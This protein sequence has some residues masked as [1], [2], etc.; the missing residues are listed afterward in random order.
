MQS[1][2]STPAQI[3]AAKERLDV[4]AS[5]TEAGVRDAL[6]GVLDRETGYIRPVHAILR[7]AAAMRGEEV[8]DVAIERVAPLTQPL[9]AHEG[10]AELDGLPVLSPRIV[11]SPEVPQ[12][13]VVGQPEP[14]VDA[15]KLAKGYPAFVDDIE[16]RGLL[17]A[18]VLYSPHAHARI[19][20]ID[21]SKARELDGVRAVLHH[22]NVKRVRYASGGQSY[23][24]PLPYDQVSFDNKVRYVGD[25]V[26][27]VAAD[28]PEIALAALDLIDVTYE[29]LPAVFEESDAIAEGA[30]VIHDEPDMEGAHD[31]S[32]NIVHH[33]AADSGDVDAAFSEADRVFE[34]TLRVHQVQPA[35]IE[36]HIAIS[37]WD[38]DER[39]VIR[40][41][42]QVPFHT[43]RMVAP[44]LGLAVKKIRIIKPRIGGG[45]GVKQEILIEALGGPLPMATG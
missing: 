27:A 8:E 6:T 24:N 20:A 23:P 17:H 32:R 28:T 5:P 35:P 12:T 37:W 3:L 14:K 4:E 40:T 2:Y 44:L 29:V 18:K 30:P 1:G 16:I 21:D 15:L 22:E 41:S 13:S 39:L 25:R 7:A 9:F 43:R 11:P 33:I 19:I 34:Q 38:S 36:P 45:F 26:A 31:A 42:T 10:A